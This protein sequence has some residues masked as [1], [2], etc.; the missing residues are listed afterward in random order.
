MTE[1]FCGC[2]GDKKTSWFGEYF[3]HPVRG[4][5]RNRTMLVTKNKAAVL[6][7]RATIFGLCWFF[8]NV[9]VPGNVRA[10]LFN[11]L[12]PNFDRQILQTGLYTFSY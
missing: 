8:V 1:G 11:P 7:K 10:G 3:S 4:K 6:N 12:R 2:G 9:N 5:S